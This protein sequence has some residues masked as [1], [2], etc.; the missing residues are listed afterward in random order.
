[1]TR[2]MNRMVKPL[3]DLKIR[4]GMDPPTG[5]TKDDSWRLGDWSKVNS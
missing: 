1:M 5:R 4:E 2:P 3:D